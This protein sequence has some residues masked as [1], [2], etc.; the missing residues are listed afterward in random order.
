MR[1]QFLVFLALATFAMACG[2][3]AKSDPLTDGVAKSAEKIDAE[4]ID[5]EKI[6]KTYCIACHGLYGDMGASGAANLQA[7]KLTLEERVTVITKGR[8][9]MAPF[10]SL[11]SPEKIQAVAA[12]TTKLKQSQ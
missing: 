5:A 11:L 12:Y 1:N 4:K 6:F 8:N 9:M 2:N 7:S 3:D 10:E